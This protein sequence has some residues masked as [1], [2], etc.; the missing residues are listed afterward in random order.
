MTEATRHAARRSLEVLAKAVSEVCVLCGVWGREC[1]GRSGREGEVRQ[2]EK[3]L[4]LRLWGQFGCE[5][6]KYGDRTIEVD[7]VSMKDLIFKWGILEH[8]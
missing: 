4:D 5:G 3:H 6:S 2:G 1:G 7:V 8:I